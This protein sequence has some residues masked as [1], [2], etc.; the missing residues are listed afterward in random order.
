[1]S[2]SVFARIS[3]AWLLALGLAAPV[4]ADPIKF[5]R[6]PHVAHG[7]LAFSYHGDI[8]I[9]NQDGSSP[10]RLTAHVGRDTFPRFSPDGKLIAF[11]SNRFGNDD[12]FVMPVAGGEPRQ[13]T[14]NTAGDQVQNWT[15]DGKG[16]I[17]S[18]QRAISPWHSP[19]YVVPVEGGLPR[20]MDMDTANTGMVKQDGSMVAFTRK[21]GAYWRKGN[22]G[23]RT[24]DIWV[25]DAAS[26][27]ITR[28]T[29]LDQA[30]VP[31]LGPRHL[32]DVG[33]RRP[34]LL[35]LRARRHLQHLEDRAGRRRARP[36]QQAYGRRDPVSVDQPRRQGD[37]V[38]ERV[39]AVD[40]RGAQRHAEARDDRHGLRSQGQPGHLGEHAEQGRRLL[41]LARG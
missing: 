16:I 9:A 10:S 7:K 2:K 26:K 20:P 32:S 1:M 38:R 17:F 30:T 24:D 5:A 35:R 39:R 28:L 21:G 4:A 23:N 11:T 25:Q 34:D 40:A 8:W 29:D 22:K 12:V 36:G 33:R 6:Y 13:L 37:R 27:K 18:S 15:P 19:L 31:R 14:F 3:C 41:P